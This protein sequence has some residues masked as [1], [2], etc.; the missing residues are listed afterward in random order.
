MGGGWGGGTKGSGEGRGENRSQKRKKEKAVVLEHTCWR[1]V[2]N[3]ATPAQLSA[4]E[5][6]RKKALE[7]RYKK[8][9]SHSPRREAKSESRKV[10]LQS[11]SSCQSCCSFSGHLVGLVC[12]SPTH[13]ATPPAPYPHPNPTTTTPPH[14]PHRFSIQASPFLFFFLFRDRHR[15]VD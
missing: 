8:N 4:S 2:S 5:L 14:P 11:R 9:L 13:P 1:S 6:Q 3:A 15:W 7:S 12:C 10:S